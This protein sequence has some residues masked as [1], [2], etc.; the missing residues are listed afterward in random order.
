VQIFFQSYLGPMHS[1]KFIRAFN[2]N[3][4]PHCRLLR[5]RQLFSLTEVKAPWRPSK[6]NGPHFHCVENASEPASTQ[7]SAPRSSPLNDLG[8]RPVM[9][10][11][12]PL[13]QIA[14]SEY[15]HRYATLAHAE[16]R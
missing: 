16:S 8:F 1:A 13:R 2:R 15:A 12:L 14:L 4:P 6:F 11:S 10:A 9:F 3:R 7:L 5:S